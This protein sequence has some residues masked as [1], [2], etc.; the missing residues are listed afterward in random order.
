MMNTPRVMY[1]MT[2]LTTSFFRS[3]FISDATIIPIRAI[4][5]M[6]SIEDKSR[7]VVLPYT[8]IIPKTKAATKNAAPYDIRE[9]LALK[10]TTRINFRAIRIS[11]MNGFAPN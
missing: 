4:D 11:V 8:A 5:P 2:Q 6:L 1:D 9:M 10:M 3:K 7:L